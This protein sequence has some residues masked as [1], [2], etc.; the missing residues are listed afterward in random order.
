MFGDDNKGVD[1]LSLTCKSPGKKVQGGRG[2]GVPSF[3][4]DRREDGEQLLQWL[5]KQ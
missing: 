3:T 2:V 4:H 5:N 1:V